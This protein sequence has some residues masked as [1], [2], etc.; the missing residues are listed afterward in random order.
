MIYT[1][2]EIKTEDGNTITGVLLEKTD[3]QKVVNILDNN[4]ENGLKGDDA[5]LLLNLKKALR[6]LN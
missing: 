5:S 1:P 2:T 4:S 3:L 6:S